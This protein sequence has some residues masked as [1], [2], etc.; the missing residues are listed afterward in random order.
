MINK[1]NKTMKI[2]SELKLIQPIK[3]SVSGELINNNA[4]HTDDSRVGITTDVNF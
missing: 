3:S 1:R 4:T 2:K